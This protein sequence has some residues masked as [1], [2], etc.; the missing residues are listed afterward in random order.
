MTHTG[1]YDLWNRLASS[2]RVRI[3]PFIEIPVADTVFW[4]GQPIQVLGG[5]AINHTRDLIGY[6]ESTIYVVGVEGHQ[7]RVRITGLAPVIG[8][9]LKHTLFK[10]ILIHEH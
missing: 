1:L 5:P 10:G 6:D 2:E 3:T 4:Y 8:A 9:S 7:I